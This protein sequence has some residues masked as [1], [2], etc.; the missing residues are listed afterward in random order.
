MADD[1]QA[2]MPSAPPST[3]MDVIPGYDAIPM[4]NGGCEYYY[5]LFCSIL[6]LML[7][8]RPM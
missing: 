5:D 2:P 6:L 8:D 4:D 7:Q 1:D 3:G